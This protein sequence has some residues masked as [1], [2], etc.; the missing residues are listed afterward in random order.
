[1]D[2]GRLRHAVDKSLDDSESEQAVHPAPSPVPLYP[3]HVHGHGH[4]HAG[5]LNTSN[6]RYS[7][8]H[9]SAKAT[10]ASDTLRR[11]TVASTVTHSHHGDPREALDASDH[12]NN[13]N[14]DSSF[15]LPFSGLEMPSTYCFYDE[16]IFVIRLRLYWL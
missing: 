13:D 3:P 2:R 7:R 10:Q 4:G 12:N 1:M 9:N 14:V 16:L 11:R 6:A 8:R 15:R 5:N